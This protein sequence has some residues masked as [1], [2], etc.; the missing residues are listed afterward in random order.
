MTPGAIDRRA[1]ARAFSRASGR[2]DAAARL[3]T[4]VRDEL[5]SRLA[6]FRPPEGLVLDLGAGTGAATPQLRRQFRERE[7]VAVDLSPAMLHQAGERLSRWDRWIDWRGRRFHRVAA[8]AVHLPFRDRSVGLV[9]SSLMLQ[10]CDDLDATLREIHRVLAPEGVLLCSTF[11]PLTLF[12]LREAWASVDS[13]PRVN[14]FVDLHDLGSALVRAGFTEPVLDVDRHLEWHE[15][16]RSVMQSLRAIGA[17]NAAR[18]R[19]RGLTG[20]GTL[21]AVDA[22]YRRRARAD[23]AVPA[24][25]EVLFASAFA[26]SRTATA[27]PGE[28]RVAA[29]AIGRRGDAR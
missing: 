4:Q 12:E 29:N 13:T 23:G 8:D 1:V 2:Y 11:G 10:W 7:V 25:W 3:Q 18:R 16:S 27:V 19:R 22:D 17:V 26:G 9:F 28:I 5:L 20:R 15:N 14:D 21:A 24:S 6:H